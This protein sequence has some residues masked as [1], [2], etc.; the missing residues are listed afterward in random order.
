MTLISVGALKNLRQPVPKPPGSVTRSEGL[1]ESRAA[2]MSSSSHSLLIRMPRRR[3]SETN[4]AAVHQRS[5]RSQLIWKKA[6][7]TVMMTLTVQRI[8][9][10]RWLR[11][12]CQPAASCLHSPARTPMAQTSNPSHSLSSRVKTR[13]NSSAIVRRR[14]NLRSVYPAERLLRQEVMVATAAVSQL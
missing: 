9:L 8:L 10:L 11:L 13:K 6:R 1:A 7:S 12:Q 5:M 14:R 2:L 3:P 4:T